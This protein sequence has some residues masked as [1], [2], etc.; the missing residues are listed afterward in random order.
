MLTRSLV[1][2]CTRCGA[3]LGRLTLPNPTTDEAEALLAPMLAAV[4]FTVRAAF[5]S[6]MGVAAAF[7]PE[8][9]LEAVPFDRIGAVPDAAFECPV[10]AELEA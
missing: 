6:L 10:C 1:L 5:K 8:R 2:P 4:P 7:A 9:P 3:P